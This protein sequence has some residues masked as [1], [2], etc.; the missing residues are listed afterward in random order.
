LSYISIPASG[1]Y[2]LGSR[3]SKKTPNVIAKDKQEG[4]K[5]LLKG[6]KRKTADGRGKA[7]ITFCF[8]K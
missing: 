1:I 5:G 3:K 8:D 6:G 4:L 7:V 2:W